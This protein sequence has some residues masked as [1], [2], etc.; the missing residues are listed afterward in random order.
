MPYLRYLHEE[1]NLD[2]RLTWYNFLWI[3]YVLY[4][5]TCP[6]SHLY[7]KVTFLLS[8]SW[9]FHMNWTAFKISPVLKVHFPCSQRWPLNASL[10]VY[11]NIF[12]AIII[13]LYLYYLWFNVTFA[14]MIKYY[15]DLL[16]C[17]RRLHR[18]C[19]NVGTSCNVSWSTSI[20]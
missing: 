18:L 1:T 4:S 14:L 7:L 3:F 10:T 19:G 2:L 15:R 11:F 17:N 20:V 13:K 8:W 5:Q 12:P 9:K 16:F 6:G